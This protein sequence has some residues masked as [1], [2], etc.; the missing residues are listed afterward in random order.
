MHKLCVVLSAFSL[1]CWVNAENSIDGDGATAAAPNP[2]TFALIPTTSDSLRLLP[3][4]RSA[5]D[6]TASA[7]NRNLELG[8]Q[9]VEQSKNHKLQI[10]EERYLP[11]LVTPVMLDIYM[12]VVG[13]HELS[14]TR[15]ADLLGISGK[16]ITPEILKRWLKFIRLYA[17]T[18]GEEKAKEAY[19][20]LTS[21]RKAMDVVGDLLQL[22]TGGDKVMKEQVAG[23]FKQL[24]QDLSFWYY[25]LPGIWRKKKVNP[26]I[27]AEKLGISHTESL[28]EFQSSAI[29]WLK[30]T[31]VLK[32]S[33]DPEELA[34]S[35]SVDEMYDILFGK[36]D[37]GKID[38]FIDVFDK[39]CLEELSKVP[40]LKSS[41]NGIG[42]EGLVNDLR[43]IHETKKKQ[44]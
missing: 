4:H 29:D 44:G 30:Y 28:S 31:M 8:T 42:V 1:F 39:T 23:M 15:V 13:V 7:A 33:K 16:S 17:A 24:S 20:V 27:L 37:R 35:I 34:I 9:A 26:V 21:R 36:M 32:N 5:V 11:E 18:G 19:R 12:K 43:K 40:V 38:K 25:G 10:N 41:V 2:M 14:P 3:S 6:S 22:E